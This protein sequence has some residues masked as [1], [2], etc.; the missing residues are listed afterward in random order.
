MEHA[1]TVSELRDI[2]LSFPEN[3]TILVYRPTNCEGDE[4]LCQLGQEGVR[5]DNELKTVVIT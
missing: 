5:Y 1:M 4:E 2:L 3:A